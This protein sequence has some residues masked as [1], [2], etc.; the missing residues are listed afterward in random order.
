MTEPAKTPGERLWEL[1]NQ[2][3]DV[4]VAMDESWP[5]EAPDTR[6]AYGTIAAAVRA[7]FGEEIK[8]R[9]LKLIES[10]RQDM[11]RNYERTASVGYDSGDLQLAI[12][13]IDE[14]LTELKP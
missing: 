5:A 1:C 3:P 9:C 12:R 14:L 8:K 11:M 4:F 2:F 6:T 13:M 10:R 7:E